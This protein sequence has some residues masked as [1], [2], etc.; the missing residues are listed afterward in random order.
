MN[1]TN[2]TESDQF[3]YYKTILYEFYKVY[4]WVLVG[5]GVPGNV[6][7]ILV[8]TSMTLTTATLYMSLLAVADL[9]ALVLKLIFHQIYLYD[10]PLNT[11]GCKADVF[12]SLV[13]CYANWTLVLVCCERFLSIRFPLKKKIYFTKKRAIVIAVL[14]GMIL[15]L[16]YIY[17][18]IQVDHRE[19]NDCNFPKSSLDFV[20]TYFYWIIAFIYLFLPFILLLIFPCLIIVS[21]R[22]QRK[23]REAIVR[24]TPDTSGE[25]TQT[26]V[27]VAISVMVVWDAI[28]VFVTYAPICILHLIELF[29][30]VKYDT[31]DTRFTVWMSLL[32]AIT[33]SEANYAVDFVIYFAA[34]K[35]FRSRFKKLIRKCLTCRGRRDQ[36]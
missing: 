29:D 24:T 27:E 26:R 8:T 34:S 21:L 7:C 31:P 4:I 33:L 9:L 11:F 23:A 1:N 5:V 13:S 36:E 3:N 16:C 19:K 25:T 28:V 30:I 18:F 22:R 6:A 17:E 32:I 10:V 14:L 35:K 12:V 20:T 2:D 15:C